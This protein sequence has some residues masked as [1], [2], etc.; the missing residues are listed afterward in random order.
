MTKK[1]Q[2]DKPEHIEN[3]DLVQMSRD[4]LEAVIEN[5]AILEGKK[6]MTEQGLKEA[7]LVLGYLNA[8]NNQVKTRMQWFK[9]TGLESKIK[10]VKASISK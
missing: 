1:Y 10:R 7:K 2:K 9:M 6:E 8:T 3:L 4:L 5:T